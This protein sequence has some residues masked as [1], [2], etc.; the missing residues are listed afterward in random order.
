MPS[1]VICEVWVQKDNLHPLASTHKQGKLQ[2]TLVTINNSNFTSGK[3]SLSWKDNRQHPPLSSIHY[4]SLPSSHPCCA[5]LFYTSCS[6]FVISSTSSLCPVS[7]PPCRD[8]LPPYLSSTSKP[9][10][11]TRWLKSFT[12]KPLLSDH[13]CNSSVFGFTAFFSKIQ[14]DREAPWEMLHSMHC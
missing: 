13:F 1:I 3:A 9:S 10:I 8:S 4:F 11:N 14:Q 12:L 7:L 5:L 2:N 6:R